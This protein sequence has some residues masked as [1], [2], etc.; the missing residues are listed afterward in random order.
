MDSDAE[1]AE[2]QRQIQ[3][4]KE[5]VQRDARREKKRRAK[6]AQKARLRRGAGIV[7]ESNVDDATREQVFSFS[8]ANKLG[9]VD[10]LREVAPESDDESVVNVRPSKGELGAKNAAN[11]EE[12]ASAPDRLEAIEDQLDSA[13]EAYADRRAEKTGAPRVEK[14]K[15]AKKYR[16]AVAARIVQDDVELIDGDV[17]QYASTLNHDSS[18][19]DDDVDAAAEASS[20]RWFANPLFD[21][22]PRTEKEVRREKRLKAKQR[23]ERR[24]LRRGDVEEQLDIVTS[25]VE[26]P[27]S[28]KETEA[29]K[30]IKAGVGQVSKDE[31]GFEIVEEDPFA[32][33]EQQL[34]TYISDSEDDDD[35]AETLALASMMLRRSKAKKLVDASYNRFAW[36][37]PRD[38]PAWFV[39]D[40]KRHYRPQVPIKPEL[41]AE[42]KARFQSLAAKPIKKVAEA[43]A[44]KRTRAEARLKAAKKRAEA[45]A[46]DPDMSAGRKLKE[47]ER[48]MARASKQKRPDKVYVVASKSKSGVRKATSAP[49]GATKGSRVVSVDARMK[50][51]KRAAKSRAKKQKKFGKRRKGRH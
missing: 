51:D 11:Y 7:E 34:K 17:E 5:L 24:D 15:R 29:R 50:K 8:E 35:K 20:K 3:H 36:N 9:G 32:R 10:A 22:M 41:L 44:R 38:L 2:V 6:A 47:V 4:Q 25:T 27:R 43:R 14:Q 30:L 13:Y 18:S 40:E 31:E 45:V 33:R 21:E 42:M 23:K 39:D 28:E 16:D 1:E 49:K 19:D 48:A 46:N 12:Y 37:D 26:E